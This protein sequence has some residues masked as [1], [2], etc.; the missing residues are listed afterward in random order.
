[1]LGIVTF[2]LLNLGL[3][4]T[5]PTVRGGGDGCQFPKVAHTVRVTAEYE[6]QA[7]LSDHT[8]QVTQQANDDFYHTYSEFD[9][10]NG[11]GAKL[12]W[13]DKL[14]ISAGGRSVH[15][16]VVDVQV[17]TSSLIQQTTE[18]KT[19]F[20]PDFTQIVEKIR[21]EVV[22]G[23][24][25]S[26]KVTTKVVG[27]APASKSV[28]REELNL[29]AK[30]YIWNNYGHETKGVIRGPS[31]VGSHCSNTTESCTYEETVC[32]DPGIAANNCTPISFRVIAEYRQ[33]ALKKDFHRR[34]LTK[35]THRQA[36]FFNI[37]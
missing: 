28:S 21:K 25:M 35:K 2:A 19:D 18:T 37:A 3:A 27:A 24:S 26:H 20:N 8:Y 22:V 12:G 30:R 11:G 7:L 13:E 10:D 1:M 32:L 5:Q 31:G 23:D 16:D 34:E 17:Q 15:N 29:R 4:L 14:S 9:T 33:Q 6:E 36:L